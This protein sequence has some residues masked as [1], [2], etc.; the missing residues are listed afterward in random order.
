MSPRGN[1]A[2]RLSHQVMPLSADKSSIADLVLV[3]IAAEGGATRNMVTRDLAPYVANKLSPAEWRR[4]AE[5][6]IFSLADAGMLTESRGR[7]HTSSKGRKRVT[8]FLGQD[9]AGDTSDV[10]TWQVQRDVMLVVKALGLDRLSAQKRKALAK[11]DGLRNLIVQH[12]FGLTTKKNQTPATLRAELAVIALERAFGKKI[13]AGLGPKTNLPA[14]ASRVLAGQLLDPPREFSTDTQLIAHIAAD[15]IGARQTS[16]EDLR[17]AL[18]C[19]LTNTLLDQTRP[20]TPPTPRRLA[21]RSAAKPKPSS[22]PLKA[23]NDTTPTN[24]K[25]TT[26]GP[27]DLPQ[28]SRIVN[29]TASSL[30]EGWPGNLKAFI[31]R[32]W[33]A[34]RD[35]HPEWNMSED[36]FKTTLVD[37]HRAG[38]L[39]LTGAD[40]KNKNDLED[41]KTSTTTY[42]NTVWYFIRVDA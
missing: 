32:V 35:G 15:K 25:T 27:P 40:L 3:R 28:F 29:A 4:M 11:P 23:A 14:K 2:G 9:K 5:G 22:A 30:A 37:A 7:L 41:F 1:E 17:L 34:I 42:K 39:V 19:R 31:S 33:R 21:K 16:L 20:A 26:D 38:H 12:S 36:A 24:L 8:S 13:K 6:A 18:I 10:T